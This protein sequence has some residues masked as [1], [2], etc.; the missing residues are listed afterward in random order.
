MPTGTSVRGS[1]SLWA[2]PVGLGQYAEA[3][4]GDHEGLVAFLEGEL[5]AERIEGLGR[6]AV[7]V[8]LELGHALGHEFVE[9]EDHVLGGDGLA[10][11]GPRLGIDMEDNP[12]KIGGILHLLGYEAVV[13]VDLV[14]GARHEGVEE[15]AVAEDE[16]QRRGRRSG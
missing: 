11:L 8:L 16:P 15:I 14:G 1:E 2:R 5:H 4:E 7:V 9:G 13:D 3:G 6:H 12:G 10:V